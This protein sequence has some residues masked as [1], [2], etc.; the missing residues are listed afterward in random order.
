MKRKMLPWLTQHTLK[1]QA[2]V[3]CVGLPVTPKK[4]RKNA[5][6][7]KEVKYNSLA[8][9]IELATTDTW[10]DVFDRLS[11]G[12]LP[13]SF[14]VR[15]NSIAYTH[16]NKSA[17]VRLDLEKTALYAAI[18][19]LLVKYGGYADPSRSVE[20]CWSDVGG[21][22]ESWSHTKKG[23]KVY[24]VYK[25]LEKYGDSVGWTIEKLSEACDIVSEALSR[26]TLKQAGIKFEEGRVVSVDGLSLEPDGVVVREPEKAKL[27]RSV[28]RRPVLARVHASKLFTHEKLY[29]RKRR[30]AKELAAEEES[31]LETR[32]STAV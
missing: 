23:T 25:Y 24:F 15:N 16:N 13:K 12:D 10:K 3:A 5:K 1:K 21:S 28:T 29:V 26:G 7:N 17:S 11:R 31:Q 18:T 22:T 4:G 8:E 9:C 30:I 27:P 19:E 32:S 6:S 14:S 2:E 20:S